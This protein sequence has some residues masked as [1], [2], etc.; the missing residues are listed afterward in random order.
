MIIPRD[1]DRGQKTLLD[2]LIIYLKLNA[3]DEYV[4][5]FI[6][7]EPAGSIQRRDFE[8]AYS[9][10]LEDDSFKSLK[11][12]FLPETSVET[13]QKN[14]TLLTD[15]FNTFLN[16]QK[17]N[18]NE[19][20]TRLEN[21]QKKVTAR[22][23]DLPKKIHRL[24]QGHCY[25]LA[26]TDAA[27]S[28]SKSRAWWTDVRVAVANWD[29]K[30]NS[31]NLDA[32]SDSLEHKVNLSQAAKEDKTGK[33]KKL[34]HVFERALNYAVSDH[35][36][37]H[38][39]FPSNDLRSKI[40]VHHA[41][42]APPP[43]PSAETKIDEKLFHFPFEIHKEEKEKKFSEPSRVK[44]RLI[45]AGDFK[46]TAERL[47]N[48][49]EMSD[50]ICLVSN[51]NHA[52]NLEPVLPVTAD[53]QFRFYDP[54]YPHKD[55]RKMCKVL[56]LQDMMKEISGRI[57]TSLII[58]LVSLSDKPPRLSYYEEIIEKHPH[59]LLKNNGIHVILHNTPD[60]LDKLFEKART[61][62]SEELYKTI[63][64]SLESRSEYGMTGFIHIIQRR[65]GLI[66]NLFELARSTP[67][68][69]YVKEGIAR[70]LQLTYRV[71]L[72]RREDKKYTK[73][74]TEQCGLAYLGKDD[75]F[76][77]EILEWS[78]YNKKIKNDFLKALGSRD[79]SDIPSY[80]KLSN[81][82]KEKLFNLAR[83]DKEFFDTL[84]AIAEASK[85]FIAYAKKLGDKE[86]YERI[87]QETIKN[88]RDITPLAQDFLKLLQIAKI[89]PSLKNDLR[90]KISKAD[91]ES[92][93]YI[94]NFLNSPD[95]LL[96]IYQLIDS[97]S[98][99]NELRK[100]FANIILNTDPGIPQLSSIVTAGTE[101]E[102]YH[103]LKA[104]ENDALKSSLIQLLKTD[105]ILDY[106]A[107]LSTLKKLPTLFTNVLNLAESKDESDL[108]DAMI[109][110]L[111]KPNQL[112]EL[113]LEKPQYS[114]SLFHFISSAGN[115]ELTQTLINCFTDSS[116]AGNVLYAIL[117]E[118]AEALPLMQK[119]CEENPDFAKSI[120]NILMTDTSCEY[121][122]VK[123][124]QFALLLKL[125][126]SNDELKVSLTSDARS[127]FLNELSNER[128]FLDYVAKN[129]FAMLTTV[130]CTV[131]SY[132][133]SNFVEYLSKPALESKD[134][135]MADILKNNPSTLPDLLKFIENVSD[136]LSIQL[137]NTL[138]T[139][140]LGENSPTFTNTLFHKL[141][142]SS[143]ER[144]VDIANLL[145]SPNTN[146]Q[147]IAVK[148][149]THALSDRENGLACL[150]QCFNSLPRELLEQIEKAL[151]THRLANYAESKTSVLAT[152]ISTGESAPSMYSLLGN[153]RSV[154]AKPESALTPSENMNIRL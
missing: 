118:G 75:A 46:E 85:E 117:T 37:F 80:K 12:T 119:L 76:I 15:S 65:P 20:N 36:T 5:E 101:L 71:R 60:L 50:V 51:E 77:S 39:W 127:T 147:A 78:T 41:I 3:I 29:E 125:I 35:H 95:E 32:D 152:P 16:Q 94:S 90:W 11:G 57:G 14:L 136:N 135:S 100:L 25:G 30:A 105:D 66:S 70:C 97:S 87:F 59:T 83:Q 68:G 31:L 1:V 19:F 9:R 150:T 134:V 24:L 133:Q 86:L 114:A 38:E 106:S 115:S 40:T 107:G 139:V 120:S 72:D 116:D 91:L 122:L 52:C 81:E 34:R 144:L 93:F 58:E 137:T 142:T 22:I 113:L 148:A 96:G 55:P 126:E 28:D 53:R 61:S 27:F 103:L 7:G 109:S 124:K 44:H 121:Q 140:L 108:Q 88:N 141:I 154:L 74:E 13:I 6:E 153:I 151:D 84:L 2:K 48:P 99:A 98:E 145:V 26:L 64:E 10:F 104:S 62:G 128:D 43:P 73:N 102:F 89:D 143:P 33:T 131:L 111:K 18:D 17:G 54:N 132:D 110:A 79:K 112:K 63:A 82:L 138:S 56:P 123:Q 69:N 21:L 130:Y 129:N 67:H 146:L 45:I 4:R 47:F 8:D 42:T 23:N 149:L 92:P 49:N